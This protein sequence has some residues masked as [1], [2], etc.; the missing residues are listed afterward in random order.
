MEALHN[1][2]STRGVSFYYVLSREPHPGFYGFVQPDSLDMRQEYTGFARAELQSEIPWI[3]DDMDNTLQKTYG[4]MPNAD[5]IIDS[6]GNLLMSNEWA[7]PVKVKEFLED[8]IGPSNISD[9]EWKKLGE[10]GMMMMGNN[11]EV[12]QIEV[13]RLSMAP[14]EVAQKDGSTKKLPFTIEA[15]TLPPGITVEGTSRLYLTIKPDEG[16]FFD[17]AEAPINIELANA[18]GITLKKDKLVSGRVRR[19]TDSYPHSLGVIWLPETGAEDMEFT[20]TIVAKLGIKGQEKK[21]VSAKYHVSGAIPKA[22]GKTDEIAA[23]RIPSLSQLQKLDSTPSTELAVPMSLETR[24]EHDTDN[25]GQGILYL[26]LKVD[27]ESGHH[28]NNL[29]SAPEIALKGISGIKLEKDLLLGADR[30]EY[31]DKDDRILAVKFTLEKGA[32]EILFEATP[33]AWICNDEEG[34]CRYFDLIYKVNGKF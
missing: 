23:A 1:A 8:R 28:W 14:L 16:V 33:A 29:A 15:G 18:K 11:D 30:D 7:D 19:G 17:N 2:Y 26:I 24:I 21:E 25:P 22:A 3:I 12:P 5:F 10:G 4:G 13:P 31:D 6:D 20:A 9:E 27:S 34:W 32:K